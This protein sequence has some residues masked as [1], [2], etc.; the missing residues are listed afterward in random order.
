MQAPSP[1]S[2]SPEVVVVGS[3]NLDTTVVVERLPAPG[4]TLLA[5][6]LHTA[7]G[8]KGANQAVTCARQGVTTA[9]VG[10][11]GDDATGR[12]LLDTLAE[13]GVDLRFTRVVPPG[14]AQTGQALI[15][16]DGAGANTV[17]VAAG[18]NAA[19]TRGDVEVARAWIS[20]ARIVLVQLEIGSAAVRAALMLGR[21]GGARNIL[22]P[23]PARPLDDGLLALCDFLIPNEHEAALLT[24]VDVPEEAALALADRARDAVVLVTCGADGVVVCGPDRAVHRR[25]AIPA[26]AIDSVAAGDAFCGALAAGLAQGRPLADALYRAL[27]AGAHAVTIPG[28]VPSLPRAAD[29]DRI[30][31]RDLPES[32]AIGPP[33]T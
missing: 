10:A 27:A 18:A 20:Q 17:I 7:M 4:E 6:G 22:N 32:P 21:T 14:M 28:A 5:T 13:E 11:V 26:T 1:P 30:L 31:G 33:A 3:V 16:V 24:G 12:A 15:T 19:L 9:F 2:P 8:G 23:A 25:R 29:V